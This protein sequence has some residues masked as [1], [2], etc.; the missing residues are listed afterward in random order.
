MQA[1]AVPPSPPPASKESKKPLKSALEKAVKKALDQSQKKAPSIHE[2]ALRVWKHFKQ[3]SPQ[4]HWSY[5]SWGHNLVELVRKQDI[6][7]DT[8]AS[9]ADVFGILYEMKL[10][11]KHAVFVLAV[12]TWSYLVHR[13]GIPDWDKPEHSLNKKRPKQEVSV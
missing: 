1:E 6:V 11:S 13:Y 3:H 2:D 7:L 4:P 12:E 8:Q 9:V 5:R 10:I